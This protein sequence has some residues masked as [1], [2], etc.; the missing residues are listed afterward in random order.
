MIRAKHHFFMYPFF[1]FY[2]FWKIKK[3]FHKVHLIDLREDT[4]QNCSILLIGNHFSWW[5]GF[6][7]QYLNQKI[8]KKKF[9][10]MMLEEQLIKN[11]FLNLTGG[12]SIA[13]NTKD[14]IKSLQYAKE[15]LMHP[16]NI[17]LMFPQGKI[18]TMHQQTIIFQKGIERINQSKNHTS[19]IFMVNVIDYFSEQKPS[20]FCYFK[21]YSSKEGKLNDIQSAYQI[22]YNECIKTQ[23]KIVS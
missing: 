6:I 8:F 22:F 21:S 9:H 2:T 12:F 11:S 15:I 1:I 23:S 19:I 7:A 13:K 18:E 4:H 17:L 20:L 3:H 14:M 5:D 16:E 10:F